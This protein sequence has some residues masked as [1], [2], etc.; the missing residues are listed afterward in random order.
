M[1]VAIPVYGT[2]VSPRFDCA[3]VLL[4]LSVENGNVIEREIIRLE[5]LNVARIRLLEKLN[6]HLLLC[7]GI[8]RYEHRQL[9]ARGVS[10]VDGIVGEVEEVTDLRKLQVLVGGGVP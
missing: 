6:V 4:I 3:P 7:G 1:R 2:R 10:V 5:R 9:T 8:R